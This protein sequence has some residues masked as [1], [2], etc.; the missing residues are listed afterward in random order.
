MDNIQIPD[1]NNQII[2]MLDENNDIENN[3]K[4]IN[5]E[6]NQSINNQSNSS[7]IK[8]KSKINKKEENKIIN[9]RWTSE[10]KT[11]F[12]KGCLLY[13]NNLTKIQSLIKTRSLSQIRSHCQKYIIKLLKKYLPLEN[14]KEYS[15]SNLPLKAS[16]EEIDEILKKTN[17]EEKDLPIIEI[18]ILHLFSNNKNEQNMGDNLNYYINNEKNGTI[19]DKI[20][21]TK[22][23]PLEQIIHKCLD[24]RNINDLIQIFEQ[25]NNNEYY[26]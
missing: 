8:D 10:E 25:L 18:Y 2:P 17:I 19:C 3:K 22:L 11:L 9:G 26:Y 6:T 5:T 16:Q 24:S 20:D 12:I 1:N 14:F 23:S 7:K 4:I 13:G 15:T 21:M